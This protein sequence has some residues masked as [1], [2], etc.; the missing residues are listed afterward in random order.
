MTLY[1]LQVRA[2]RMA[3][4]GAALLLASVACSG[5]LDVPNPQAFGDDALNDPIILKTVTDGA[6][7]ALHQAY[8]DMIIVA[9]L[10]S[11]DME[12]TST[13]IDWED[14]SEGRLRHDWPTG[15]SFS[16]PQDALLRARFAA[17]SAAERVDR[18]LGTAAATSA[19]RAQVLLMD[20]LADLLIGM[21]WCEGPLTANAAR[22]PDTEFFKAAVTKLT[23]GLTAAQ[24]ISSDNAA[25]AKWTD[26]AYAGRARANL[27]AG[28]Y[29]AAAS[30]ARAVSAGFVY[31]AVFQELAQHTPGN[32][33]HQNRNRS[34]GLRRMYHTRVHEIDPAGTG[35]AYMRD[36][37]DPTKDDRRMAITRRT[38]QLGVNNRFPYYGIT[39]YNDRTGPIRLLSK[40]E[41]TLIEAEVA[42]RNNDFAGMT[43]LINS[44]RARTGVG[45]PAITVPTSLAAAQTAL[46]NERQA[47]LFVEGHRQ[48]DM[49]RFNL[50]TSLLG[51]G[52]AVKLPL[53]RNE[54]L[55]NTSMTDGGGTCP[56]IS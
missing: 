32:Q 42:M 43:T 28:N 40:V 30:D 39:K 33:F 55:N 46:L 12:S 38:G 10:N 50:T 31:N 7:G 16:G 45:L 27:L 25:R 41:M 52:K 37:F 17:Q 23:A 19:L 3:A 48:Q 5:A 22:S 36:W 8:D 29:A 49:V 15:G 6:E 14:I 4:Y 18:V 2:R 56:R 35:E 20:G 44:L 51:P 34:G 13:W 11:D 47:E 53:S 9:E 1:T 24:A 54:I 26:V 21:G